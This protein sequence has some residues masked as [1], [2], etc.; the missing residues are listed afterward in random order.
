MAERKTVAV[1]QED[2]KAELSRA[3]RRGFLK[4]TLSLGGLA[5]L[6]GCDL[7]T[8]SGVDAALESMLRFDDRVQAALFGS[9][10]LA[11]TYSAADITRPFRFNAFYPDW[12]V[13]GVPDNWALGVAGRVARKQPWTLPE[14]MTLPQASQIT[15]HI[16]IEGWSQ[17]GQWSGIPLRV[18]LERVGADLNSRYVAFKCFDGYS[19]SIDMASALHPQTILALDFDSKPLEPQWGAPLRLRIPTKLGFKSAKNLEAIEVTNVFPGG[20]W[21]QQGY[22]W[23]AGV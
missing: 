21:E 5:M 4:R 19:T 17:I 20:Y 1:R 3:S 2:I 23:F 7:S 13:R 6:S 10:R 18:F 8:H 15:R 16:C 9:Q 14:L 11:R 12:Q 22:D